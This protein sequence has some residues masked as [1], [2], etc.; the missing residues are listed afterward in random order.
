MRHFF[1]L[2][3][4]KLGKAIST[5][6]LI[7]WSII[8]VSVKKVLIQRRRRRRRMFIVLERDV[9]R[10]ASYK[11]EKWELFSSNRL[12]YWIQWL[13]SLSISCL[14]SSTSIEY[15]LEGKKELL[16]FWSKKQKEKNPSSHSFLEEFETRMRTS[17]CTK[18]G[19]STNNLFQTRTWTYLWGNRIWKREW[20]CTHWW[21]F[22]IRHQ[23]KS[24]RQE[25]VCVCLRALASFTLQRCS[26]FM[27][28]QNL[29]RCC[30]S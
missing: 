21:C 19:L 29:L 12:I 11:V 2:L 28:T 10:E 1:P 3:K 27:F 8:L 18:L 14:E 23:T 24:V 30:K 7:V 6:S 26:F 20:K 16:S 13:D 15:W 5:L 22:C 9:D 17:H 4:G 25:C